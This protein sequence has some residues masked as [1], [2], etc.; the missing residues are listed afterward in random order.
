MRKFLC[1]SKTKFI[2]MNPSKSELIVIHQN[3]RRTSIAKIKF[4]E[5]AKYFGVRYSPFLIS[6]GVL[7]CTCYK[8]YPEAIITLDHLT[9]HRIKKEDSNYYF[10]RGSITDKS[11]A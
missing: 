11:E 3:I 6:S 7:R 10:A 5:N 9:L 1:F 4:K 8:E 2:K